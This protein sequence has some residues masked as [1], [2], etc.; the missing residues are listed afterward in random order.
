MAHDPDELDGRVAAGGVPLEAG[1]PAEAERV[2][3][4][5]LQIDVN[6]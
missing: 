5:A 3:K 4:D 1:K 2:A 6:E